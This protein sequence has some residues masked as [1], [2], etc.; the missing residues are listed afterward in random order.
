MNDETTGGI[1]A[2]RGFRKQFLH[3]L[4][5]ILASGSEVFYPETLEDFSVRDSTGKL[6]E[7]VQVKDHTAP[8]K[9]SELK[10]FFDRAARFIED[11]SQVQIVLATY[12]NLGPELQ[13]HIGANEAIL[14]KKTSSTLL[15]CW[16]S[17]GTSVLFNSKKMM[18]LTPSR[19]IL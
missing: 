12:G 9:F 1:P 18:K 13:K 11:Y 8:L 14:K 5:R 16:M 19:S 2:L 10:T 3:T 17:S 6:I 4:H 15:I 7:I